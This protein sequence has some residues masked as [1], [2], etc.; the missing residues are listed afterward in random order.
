MKLPIQHQ[1][2]LELMC[3]GLKNSEVCAQLGLKTWAYTDIRERLLDRLGALN[4]AQ[5]GVLAERFQLVPIDQRNNIADRQ[6]ERVDLR[7][8]SAGQSLDQFFGKR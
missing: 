4:D 8:H 2:V 1:R 3:A 5:L 6:D 7:R